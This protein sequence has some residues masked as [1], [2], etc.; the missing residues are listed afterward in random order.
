MNGGVERAMRSL[1][2]LGG[3]ALLCCAAAAA[4]AAS[5]TAAGNV[6]GGSGAAGQVDAS[7][8]PGLE[9]EPTPPFSKATA[10]AAQTSR[11]GPPRATVHR[12]L[13]ASSS[14][15]SPETTPLRATAGPAPTTS[16][17]PLGPSP[18]APVAGESTATTPRPTT[19][20]APTTLSATT[21]PAPT[22]PVATTVPAPTTPPTPTPGVPRSSVPP[23]PPATAAPSL[24]PPPPEYVC[25]CSVVG[26]LDVNRCNQ[27]T[28]QCECL[29][30]YQ[31]LHCE[32]CKEGFYL[33]HTSGLCLPC[34]CSPHGALSI[35]CNSSGKCQCKVGVTG[36]ACDRC[37]DGYYG[38][39]RSGC[40][41]CQC[42]NRSASCDALT[43]ACLNCLGN[44]KGDH[45][46]ECKEGFYQSPGATKECFRC[47]CSAVTSTGSCIIKLGELE[48]KCVQ[49]K[50]GYTGQNCNKCENG[51]YN[52]DSICMKCQCNGHVDPIKTPK[53]CKPES[54]ECINCLHNTTGFWCENCLEGYVRDLE[55][56]CIKKEVIVPTP[57]GSTILVSNASLT[58]SVP[59]PVINSTFTPT[60]LQTIFSVS[61]AENSTSALADVSWT[62]FNIIILTVIIIVVVLLMGFVGAVYMYREYQNRKLNAPF[63]TIELKEDNISFSSYHDS[64]PN[65][66]VSGLL[67]DDCNEVT[68]NGQLT[69]TTSMH[70]YKA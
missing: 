10:T 16:P 13:T 20:P 24:P 55:E 51:Y 12:P 30:G 47:P 69:L 22:S 38:F 56:N 45:C 27:T 36:S 14:A 58:T 64:I 50:E 9:G 52:Y 60:T 39:S 49:C 29:P 44:S 17:A 42:N 63:W 62:Q 21:G 15:G 59:T 53:I 26:S 61:S 23:T 43:G 67:E 3:L 37:Q 19:R 18:A 65:A 57:E 25:N 46:E 28:G 41:P 6:T 5:V 8:S 48:P 7:P 11:T 54:G 4:A 32:T 1:P 33:N 66:D 40:L 34:E 70:N 31:G 35:L 2:S 68:P